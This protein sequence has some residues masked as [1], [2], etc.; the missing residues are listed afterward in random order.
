L[1]ME[2]KKENSLR[3]PSTLLLGGESAIK[4]KR[5]YPIKTQKEK[6]IGGIGGWRQGGRWKL[7]ERN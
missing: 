4:D 3:G 6:K 7:S 1:G 2:Y 5:A